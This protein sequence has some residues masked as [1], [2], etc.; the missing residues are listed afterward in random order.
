MK[1]MFLLISKV[2]LIAHGFMYNQNKG[3]DG[4]FYGNSN[5]ILSLYLKAPGV[6]RMSF[7]AQSYE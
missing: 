4:L 6:I 2:N 7:F 5:T 1:R 3:N